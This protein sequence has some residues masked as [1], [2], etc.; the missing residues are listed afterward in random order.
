M[1]L[2][3]ET[4]HHDWALEYIGSRYL[5]DKV[6]FVL[7][8]G[9]SSWLSANSLGLSPKDIPA[10]GRKRYFHSFVV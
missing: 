5:V 6:V 4:D 3:A 9:A 10:C 1:T 7:E 2:L 8:F